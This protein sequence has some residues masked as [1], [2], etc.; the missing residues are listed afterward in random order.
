M[1]PAV[2]L[3]NVAKHYVHGRQRLDVLEGLDLEVEAGEFVALTGPSGS[4]KTTLLNLMAG[5]ARAD[6]GTVQV[7]GEALGQLGSA[8]LAH[9]RAKNVG[10]VAQLQKLSPWLT[11]E[12]NVELPLLLSGRSR[13][14]R[15]SDVQA[16]LQF[17]GMDARGSHEPSELSGGQQQRVAIARALVADPALLLCDE[18]TGALDP[19]TAAEILEL[20]ELVNRALGTTVVMVTHDPEATRRAGRHLHMDHGRLQAGELAA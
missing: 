14:Q 11:A 8:Q 10:F 19:R 4:G 13:E 5:I 1:Q 3:H 18:P 9:W 17:V 6:Q 16:A 15:L 20:L 12:Q 7:M 2:S